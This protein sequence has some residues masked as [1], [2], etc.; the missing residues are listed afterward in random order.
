MMALSMHS[1]YC[2]KALNFTR[3]HQGGFIMLRRMV[4]QELLNIKQFFQRKL[5]KIKTLN[6]KKIGVCFMVS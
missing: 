6:L 5:S 3:V 2:G 4:M 1:W